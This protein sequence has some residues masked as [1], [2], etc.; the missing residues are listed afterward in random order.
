MN[1]KSYLR[2][3]NVTN[4]YC[5]EHWMGQGVGLCHVPAC[6]NRLSVLGASSGTVQRFSLGADLCE[7]AVVRNTWEALLGP[8][9]LWLGAAFK[10]SLLNFLVDTDV[11][12]HVISLPSPDPLT[13]LLVWILHLPHD[14]ICLGIWTFDWPW[15]LSLDLLFSLG[16]CGNTPHFN[17][18]TA[19]L[20]LLSPLALSLPFLL[21]QHLHLLLPD[22]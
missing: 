4:G 16:S 8:H 13:W 10:W 19:L 6:T 14:W 5:P 22:T 9:S 2:V 11:S 17:K 3:D 18:A 12:S 7:R 15:L 20:A 21:E 1:K